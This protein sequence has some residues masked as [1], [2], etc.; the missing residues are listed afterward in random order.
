[1][2]SDISRRRRVAYTTLDEFLEDAR[3][4]LDCDV[5][6]VGDWSFAQILAHLALSINSSIDGFSYRGHWLV[7]TFVAPL[8]KNRLLNS[9]MKPGFQ[10]PRRAA[11][12]LP[13]AATTL[14]EARE[15]LENAIRRLA[16]TPPTAE[17]PYLGSLAADEWLLLHLRHAELHMSFV[18]PVFDK[19]PIANNPSGPDA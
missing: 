16:G 14:A 11:A 10:I 2:A 17:H 18:V 1:M 19:Q 3:R 12:Y 15:Q 9:P 8:M 6:T 7:R 13:A 4:L 5:I